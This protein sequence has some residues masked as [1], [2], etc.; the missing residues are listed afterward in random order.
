MGSSESLTSQ[1]QAVEQRL[2]E[3]AGMSAARAK[4][5]LVQEADVVEA[6]QV[7]AR[8]TGDDGKAADE[9]RSPDRGMVV[10]SEDGLRVRSEDKDSIAQNAE[11]KRERRTML[12]RMVEAKAI[13]QENRQLRRTSEEQNSPNTCSNHHDTPEGCRTTR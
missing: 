13:F 10:R 7:I 6:N 9:V 11:L 12:Q 5:L 4:Q 8:V 1:Y 3:L 2:E